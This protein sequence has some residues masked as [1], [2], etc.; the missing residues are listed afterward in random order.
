M[1]IVI[2]EGS[3][4]TSDDAYAYIRI[5]STYAQDRLTGQHL[6]TG[7]QH[8][9]DTYDRAVRIALQQQE[10]APW[11]SW[12]EV[13]NPYDAPATAA[14]L[15]QTIITALQAGADYIAT[16]RARDT[17]NTTNMPT[18]ASTDPTHTLASQHQTQ[19]DP[20]ERNDTKQ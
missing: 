3:T 17:P 19:H 20:Q 7:L 18:P 9:K 4:S 5:D 6:R 14:D 2:P 13:I 16:A 8:L 1:Q 12:A 11:P 15:H 10:T